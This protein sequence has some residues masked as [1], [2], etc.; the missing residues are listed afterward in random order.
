[1]P[2]FVKI[3]QG[4]VDKAT[5]DQHVPAHQQYVQHLNE[6]GFCAQTGYWQDNPGGMLI[7]SAPNW[8]TAQEIVNQDPLVMHQCVRYELHQWIPVQGELLPP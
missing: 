3:E 1:M 8:A 2:W 6:Q 7:F 5:F 4:I